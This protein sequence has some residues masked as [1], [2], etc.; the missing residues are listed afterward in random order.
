MDRPSIIFIMADDMGYGDVGCYNPE[1][2][3]PTPNMDRLAAEGMRFTDAHASSAVCTPSRY[4]VVTGRYCWRSNLKRGVN[5][6]HTLPIIDPGR[7]T[8]AR[9]LREAGYATAAVGKW[10]LGLD[11]QPKAGYS[12]VRGEDDG[13]WVDYEKPFRGG[14]LDLGFDYFFGISASLDMPPY[15]FLENDRTVGVPSLP[16]QPYHAQQ[17]RGFM[18][19]GWD[20]TQVDVEHARKAVA[21]LEGCHEGDPQQ[22]FFLYLTPSN[23]HRPCVPPDFVKGSSEAGPRGDCVALVDWL[24]GE[25]TNCLERLGRA[26]NTLV[27]VT[28]DNGAR[29]ADVDGKTHGH[30]SCGDLR[31]YKS[32]IWEGGHREPFLVRWPAVVAAGST[33]AETVCLGDL[34][35]TAAAINGL[36]LPANAAEDSFSFL[37]ALRGEASAG[38]RTEI[39]HHSLRGLFSLREGRWKLVLGKGGGG[40]DMPELEQEPHVQSQPG[41]LYDMTADWRETTNLYERE[42]AVAERLQNRLRAIIDSGRSRPV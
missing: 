17:R 12:A 27:I 2:R 36:A 15:C 18:T 11:W 7:L 32:H 38:Q 1:S 3:I 13:A 28:S 26:E 21:W 20:D 23:P 22:P 35:A 14:P 24:V 33:C 42:P 6:G 41:Q 19:P 8:V 40:F 9:M 16:K 10:H 29:P 25:I 37:P 39:V 31:G 5:M 4:S 34:M 30:K